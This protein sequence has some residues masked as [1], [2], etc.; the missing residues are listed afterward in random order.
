MERWCL[1]GTQAIAL[2]NRDCRMPIGSMT[3]PGSST[4]TAG[5]FRCRRAARRCATS[6]TFSTPRWMR[7]NAPASRTRS[8]TS[9]DSRSTTRTCTASRS[10]HAADARLPGAAR[11]ARTPAVG[12]RR[13]TTTWHSRGAEFQ[14]GASPTRRRLR[15]RQ[16]EVG[17]PG[18]VR[19]FTIARRPVTQAAFLAFVEDG[20]Y[21]REI[22]GA[23]RAGRGARWLR[24]TTPRTGAEPVRAGSNACSIAGSRCVRRRRWR[25]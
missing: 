23:R 6:T 9:S 13:P 25:M 22:C 11:T 7:C 10:L 16:R 17:A 18:R 24:P 8:C 5:G 2:V 1:R 19:A 21:R 4:P 12:V 15:V 3:R 14:Q 20:G